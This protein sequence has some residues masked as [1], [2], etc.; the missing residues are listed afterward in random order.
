MKLDLYQRF[1]LLLA[2]L[3]GG[4]AESSC[5]A[6]PEKLAT[7]LE[8]TCFDCHDK[9]TAKGGLDLTALP[10]TLN[11]A[12][13]REH[14]IRIH[15]RI[16]KGEMPPKTEDLAAPERA[17]MVEFLSTAIYEQDHAEVVAKGRGPMRRLNRDEYEQ[18]LR[19]V[20]QLP[21]LDIRDMLP[22]DREGHHFNK[23]T[24]TLDIS[25]V[26]LTAYL[27][28]ADSALR[29]AMASDVKP[30]PS[31]KV[32]V[33]GAKLFPATQTFGNREAMFFAK[34]SKA[35][36]VKQINALS[37]DPDLEMALFRSAHW[38]YFG[39]PQGFTAKLAGEYRLR[40][41][42]RAVLQTPGFELKPA[43]QSVPMTFRARKPSGADVSGDVR[44]TGGIMDIRPETAVYETTVQLRKGETFEYSL[45]GLP[46]PLAR[47]VNNG[48]PSYRYPP[49]PQGGQPGVA[50]Q[51]LETEGPI[52]SSSWP[53]PSHYVLFGDLPI[54]P[55]QTK[56]GL[57]VDVLSP[58]PKEDVHR[59]LIRFVKL[60]AREPVPDAVIQKF[61]QL[62]LARLDHG[63]PFAEAMLAAYKTFLCSSHFLYLHEPVQADDHFAIASRLSHFL[64]NTRPDAALLELA[65]SKKLRDEA[66]LKHETERLIAGES[67]G[68]F[69]KSFTDYWLNLRHVHRD[70][71]DIRLYPEYRFDD[72]LV[73]SMER[74]T[75]S[76]F[77][78]MIRDNLPA[79][80][81]VDADFVFANDC[82]AKHYHLPALAG[83]AMRKVSLPKESPFGGLLTQAAI[84]KVTANGTTTSPVVRGAWIMERLM[85]EPP[86]PPP[87]SVPAVEPDIRGAKTIR[88]LLALHTKSKS[89]AACH[90]K[91]DPV[92]LALENFDILGGWRSR[93]RGLE[94]GE[95]ITGIDRAGHDFTYTLAAPVDA[96]GK[97]MDGRSFQNI[98][99]LKA[100]FAANPRQLA[101]NLLHQFTVYATGTPVRFS[102]RAEI[103]SMLDACSANGYR[104]RDLLLALV[105]S[106]IFLGQAGTQPAK[107]HS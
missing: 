20:L 63:V 48:P 22:E 18:N 96:A 78:A 77:T 72:Y 33:A 87:P 10:F 52:T 24:E 69:V 85:G 31:S 28:A 107:K 81:L 34:D 106:K 84:L 16:N 14:W 74:E 49:F 44:A 12:S 1:I 70:E 66:V 13:V 37:N 27:E 65:R 58:Q 56:D 80:S 54:R 94:E 11:D 73:D 64:T 99:D 82:L 9:E 75:Q 86:P 100:I 79:T 29:Q 92:G 26:Q 51:W 8:Q 32:R 4:P 30:P 90:A 98:R 45:L 105:Q 93:Y 76:F 7:L 15:D 53:P 38:P 88:D 102:D 57:P 61:E 3:V 103:E 6:V 47:N 91:F 23:T 25:R 68:R 83:S 36:D 101:R 39:Y 5:G 55:P 43:I 89:C 60:A 67:F 35:V 97:L 62:A 42:A 21:L 2:L 71:P 19:D 95:R 46:M 17:S 59:L 104:V 50:F 41:S 40:F